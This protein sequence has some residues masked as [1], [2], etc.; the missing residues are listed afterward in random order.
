[1]KDINTINIPLKSEFDRDIKALKR[2][3]KKRQYLQIFFGI[4]GSRRRYLNKLNV[5]WVMM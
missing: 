1:M 4:C 2:R 5:S 3:R